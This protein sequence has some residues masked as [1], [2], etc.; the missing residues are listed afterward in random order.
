MTFRRE[1]TITADDLPPKILQA[2]P[3][4]AGGP[5]A[6]P[7]GPVE[8]PEMSLKAFLRLKEKEYLEY[9]LKHTGGDKH[10]GGRTR[11]QQAGSKRHD[12]LFL[13]E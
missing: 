10:R 4:A 7:A 12:I 11:E 3:A 9:M 1:N 8:Y 13:L 5:V 2:A 6:A